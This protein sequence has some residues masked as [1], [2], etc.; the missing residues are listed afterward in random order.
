MNKIIITLLLLFFHLNGFSIEQV[1]VTA[2]KLNLRST[3]SKNS[4]SLALLE[5]GDTLTV[6]TTNDTWTRV[7]YKSTDGFVSSEYVQPITSAD[8]DQSSSPK[9]T[10]YEEFKSKK[11]FV[12]GFKFIFS[13]VF[14][15]VLII[16]IGIYTYKMR[17][18]DGRYKTGFRQGEVST[19]SWIKSSIYAIVIALIVGFIGG[20]IS[21]FH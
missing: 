5:K 7:K 4:E 16:F 10:W 9:K 3:D 20:L 15:I 11:G 14:L 8:A 2:N 18:K 12:A 19:G 1:V 21:I 6:L 17:Q 13:R